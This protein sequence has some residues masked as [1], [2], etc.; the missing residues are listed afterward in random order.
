MNMSIPLPG[1]GSHTVAWQKNILS[2]TYEGNRLRTELECE[3]SDNSTLHAELAVAELPF[4]P[5]SMSRAP[6][7]ERF[8]FASMT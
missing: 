6:K 2:A 7:T 3:L 8:N 4:P 1:G 5:E